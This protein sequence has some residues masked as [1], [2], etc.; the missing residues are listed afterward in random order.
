MRQLNGA[1]HEMQM[2]VPRQIDCV[3]DVMQF[4]CSGNVL[5][6]ISLKHLLCAEHI[7][8]RQHRKHAP[9][10]EHYVCLYSGMIRNIAVCMRQYVLGTHILMTLHV[11]SAILV[12]LLKQMTSSK[13]VVNVKRSINIVRVIHVPNMP[14]HALL[15]Y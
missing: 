13:R 11:T 7:E 4:D 15:I 5:C 3:I 6:S 2:F 1:L 10:V 12:L 8:Q 9:L 14:C